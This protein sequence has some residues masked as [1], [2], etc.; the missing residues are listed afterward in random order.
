L[1][2]RLVTISAC[3]SAGSRIYSADGL[4]GLSWAF[5][6]AGAHQVIAALWEV[7][8]A[9]TPK[10]MDTLYSGIEAGEE[11]SVALRG[12]KLALLRSQSVYSRPYYWASFVL[13]EGN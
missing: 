12:A 6:R 2:A 10:M 3:D 5:L 7:N 13:Y 1:N 11:P 4:V 8:D 9:S